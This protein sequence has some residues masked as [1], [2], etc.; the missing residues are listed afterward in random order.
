MDMSKYNKV[1]N[2]WIFDDTFPKKILGVFVEA[3]MYLAN[4]GK[5]QEVFVLNINGTDYLITLFKVDFSKMMEKY[6]SDT[7]FW[8]GC[9][10]YMTKEKGKYILTPIEEKI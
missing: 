9:S 8:K 6:G 2:E 5:E 10:F 7:D 4:S 1:K 3:K